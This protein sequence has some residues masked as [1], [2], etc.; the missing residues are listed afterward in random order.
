M[1]EQKIFLAPFIGGLNTELTSVEE[2]PLNTSDELN[3]TIYPER[4]R[5]RRYGFDLERDGT[6]YNTTTTQAEDILTPNQTDSNDPLKPKNTT[7]SS[8]FWKNCGKT[9]LD[10]LVVQAG[11]WLYFFDASEKPFEPMVTNSYRTILR[12][13]SLKRFVIDETKFN[14]YRVNMT[15]GDG[16]LI[17]VSKYM[18]PV[19]I[20]YSPIVKSDNVTSV[21]VFSAEEIELYYRDFEGVD[22]GCK[23]EQTPSTPNLSKEHNYNLFNQGWTAAAINAFHD[24]IGVWPSNNL[25]WFVGKNNSGVFNTQTLLQHYFGNS[26][27]PRGHYILDYF[28][29]E[30]SAAAGIYDAAPRVASYIYDKWG[31]KDRSLTVVPAESIT[32]T[33]PNSKGTATTATLVFTRLERKSGKK[34]KIKYKGRIQYY[35]E[36]LLEGLDGTITWVQLATKTSI[37]GTDHYEEVDFS[38]QNST[39]YKQYRIRAVFYKETDQTYSYD[40]RPGGITVSARMPI[41]SDGDL[42]PYQGPQWRVTDVAFLGGRYFYLCGDSVLF[43]QTVDENNEGYNKCYQD[44]DP[45][46]E[47]ISD[48]LPTDG[49]VIRFKTMGDGVSLLAFNRG[50]LVF[51][52]DVVYNIASPADGLFT[53]TDYDVV[54]LSRAGICG[55]KSAVAVGDTVYYWSPMGIYKIG[56]NEYTGDTLVATNISQESIQSFY[57]EIP[58]FSKDNAVGAFDYTNN[59]IYWYYPTSQDR[60]LSLDGCLVYDLNYNSFMPQKLSA[61]VIRDM[62]NMSEMHHVYPVQVLNSYSVNPV[63][64]LRAGNLR[65]VASEGGMKNSSGNRTYQSS[66]V[67]YRL[68]NKAD[69]GK[70][71]IRYRR[72]EPTGASTDN[73]LFDW[74]VIYEHTELTQESLLSGN[75]FD[76]Y[77]DV[78]WVYD[79]SAHNPNIYLK[80]E[81]ELWSFEQTGVTKYVY[82]DADDFRTGDYAG[83]T[84][85]EENIKYQ[86]YT[87]LLHVIINIFQ[88]NGNFRLAIGFADYNSREY[89]DFTN[90]PY[91]SYMVSRPISLQ[92]TYFNKQAPIMQTLFKRT[93]ESETKVKEEYVSQS[94]AMIRV[95]WGW[96]FAD[97]SNR[98]DIIQNGYR[99]Q[100]D[101]LYDEYVESRL[102]VRG[103]GK[104]FQVEIRNDY[105]KDFRLAGI[106]MLVRV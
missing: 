37:Q 45:T 102:H 90:N 30:R 77:E 9:D 13:I 49:G 70:T 81:G 36:G 94:G 18:K 25:Q 51:G 52:R 48:M 98:W 11:W 64:F 35:V 83:V 69:S 53:A 60:L 66:W 85:V 95:R 99:P 10:V 84:A 54:E 56:V 44:A 26:L 86:R 71:L 91:D 42:F 17:V 16:T 63:Q 104:A 88:Q 80:P 97:K 7:F 46:S 106:N 93:E 72:G 92:D 14:L 29:R 15:T 41:G 31:K 8:F 40:T 39:S 105:N 38:W 73:L 20:S 65:V 78:A 4:L 59:R 61:G 101:F 22:D 100:K 47:E 76:T 2:A 43:S 55:P 21:H 74:N 96:S 33:F 19:R 32:L 58:A 24:D 57:N 27:A 5:G 68:I 89:L 50:V 62:S 82:Q 87:S 34:N 23:I 3:V 67:E 79:G 12:Y 6:L 75:T 1:P 28:K 103:R